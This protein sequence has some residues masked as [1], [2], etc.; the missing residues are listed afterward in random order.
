MNERL[1]DILNK[2]KIKIEALHPVSEE[3]KVS[4]G[5]NNGFERLVV[6]CFQELEITERFTLTTHLGHHFPDIS[7]TF[8]H[9][10]I[11]IEIKSR[12]DGSWG[13][14]GNSVM[15]SISMEDYD[16]IYTFFG[17]YQKNTQKF[18]VKFKPYWETTKAIKVT[19]SPRFTINM[20]DS[21]SV[22]KNEEEYKTLRTLSDEDRI[23]FL[24][25]YFS[26]NINTPKWYVS[27]KTEPESVPLRKLNDIQLNDR[28]KIISELF[29]IFPHDLLK[30]KNNKHFSTY[31]RCTAYLIGVHYLYTNNIRDFFTSGGVYTINSVAFPAIFKR[32]SNFKEHINEVLLNASED[33]IDMCQE[34]WNEDY[35]F[36][37]NKNFQEN[38]YDLIDCIGEKHY[39]FL[40]DN[41]PDRKLSSLLI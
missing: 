19:H 36:N 12:L 22:F 2:V 16:S 25:S 29:V 37:V 39:S 14:N 13:T 23:E 7:I 27:T 35:S 34:Y 15:E 1:H 26:E 5:E 38:Y 32:L 10:K 31:D 41:L 30:S 40:L 18:L 6:K 24:Q 9:Y 4:R 20:N 33:F 21:S 3:Y 8:N 11:G 28:I 17:S